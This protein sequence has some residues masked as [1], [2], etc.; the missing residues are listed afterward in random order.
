MSDF[1]R[2]KLGATLALLGTLFALHPYL[3]D[4]RDVGFRVT[5]VR[6][7]V[8][9]A[10]AVMACLLAVAVHCFALEMVRERPFSLL[11]RL[12]NSAFALAVLVL[13]S[14]G[15]AAMLAYAGT[16]L[17]RQL[18]LPHLEWLTPAV[19][20]G[21]LSLWLLFAVLIRRRLTRQDQKARFDHLA[22]VET[23]SLRRAQELFADDHYDLAVVEVWRALEARLR[24]A[25]V[26]RS[27][28]G[29]LDDWNRLRDAAHQYGLLAK[30]PLT[31]LDELRRHWQ[32]A[33]STE[34]L[35]RQA[36]E[37]ALATARDVLATIPH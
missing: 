9:H 7:E 15:V 21:L 28:R 26:A 8:L 23:A 20:A 1:K 5:D 4:L 22:D 16:L 19:A 12:G 24:R 32:V 27:V 17:A 14:Y 31:Q 35:P 18:D 2:T 36:A 3:T 29:D 6:I 13:P 34:P 37:A 30:V 25:L 11:E 33:V 10:L